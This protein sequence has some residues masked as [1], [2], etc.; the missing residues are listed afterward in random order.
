MTVVSS[1]DLNATSVDDVK[2][3]PV[4]SMQ[5]GLTGKTGAAINSDGAESRSLKLKLANVQPDRAWRSN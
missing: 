2:G 1:L 3:D 5:D 4:S